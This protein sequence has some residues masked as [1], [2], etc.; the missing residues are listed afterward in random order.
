MGEPVPF[1]SGKPAAYVATIGD[2]NVSPYWV[3]TPSGQFPIRGTTWT[4]T[5][6]SHEHERMAPM[7]IILCIFFIW[8][9]FLGCYSC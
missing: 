1:D 7:G 8:L 2:I 5:D 6:M 4:V 3:D 9:C